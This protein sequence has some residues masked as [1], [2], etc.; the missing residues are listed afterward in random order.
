MACAVNGRSGR[1]ARLRLSRAPRPRRVVVVGAGPAGLEAARVAALRGHEVTLLERQRRLGGA[2][3]FAAIVHPENEPLLDFLLSEITRLPVDVRTGHTATPER[4]AALRPE[5]VI[6]ATGG[7]VVT[8]RIAG[9][10]QAHVLTGGLLRAMLTGEIEA[11]EGNEASGARRL[12]AWQRLGAW[13]LGTPLQKL[14]TP[15]RV[16]TLSKYWMPL[17]K[18]VAIVG[19]DLA[20]VELAEFLASRGRRVALLECG[21]EIAPEVGL[22]RRTEHMD[23]LDR[24]GVSVNTRVQVLR[25]ER[26]G[27]ILQREGAT[28]FTDADSVVLAG[29]V[30]ADT[31]LFEATRDRIE[32]THAIGDCTGLGLIHKATADAVRVACAI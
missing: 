24:L 14:V 31:E 28:S 25:I 30:A 19:A 10:D 1:E 20:A 9:Y 8:P 3:V 22:K 2:L 18:R 27:L 5:A 6:V 15:V 12:P 29:E 11:D 4:I 17:G 7:R 16:R 23:R 32:E 13:A 26:Q 21:P